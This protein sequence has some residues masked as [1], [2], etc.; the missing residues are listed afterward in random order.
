[1]PDQGNTSYSSNSPYLRTP[2]SNKIFNKNAQIKATENVAPP[3][4]KLKFT[5][6]FFTMALNDKGHRARDRV[7]LKKGRTCLVNPGILGVTQI[8]TIMI[9]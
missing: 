9:S 8:W 7:N 1:M 4:L 6:S 2:K 3:G 5:C